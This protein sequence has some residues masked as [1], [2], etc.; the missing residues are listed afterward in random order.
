M[1]D[2]LNMGRLRGSLKDA[3]L[4]GRRGLSR[5]Q[6]HTPANRDDGA[7]ALDRPMGNSL[8]CGLFEEASCDARRLRPP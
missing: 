6:N 4:A 5:A 2:E 1:G 7:I 3:V 8:I